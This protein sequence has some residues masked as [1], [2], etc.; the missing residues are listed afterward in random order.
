M[1]LA[2]TNFLERAKVQILSVSLSDTESSKDFTINTVDMDR[3]IVTGNIALHKRS[4]TYENAAIRWFL[5]N[6][7]T[8]RV[9]RT[10]NNGASN[11]ASIQI[12]QFPKGLIQ[13]IQFITFS[14]MTTDLIATKSV[15]S[16][17]PSKAVFLPCGLTSSGTTGD[18]ESLTSE[19][20]TSMVDATTARIERVGSNAVA[21]NTNHT[22]CLVEF[23]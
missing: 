5:I 7:N 18:A 8:L 16:V 15:N 21:F 23:I 4:A 12:I 20:K 6:S 13:S 14:L 19:A 22:Y 17:N 10:N 2:I 1:G 9:T 11:T 3:T